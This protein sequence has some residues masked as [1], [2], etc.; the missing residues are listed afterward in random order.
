MTSYILFQQ[1]TDSDLTEDETRDEGNF[2]F[3][4]FLVNVLKFY[5]CLLETCSVTILGAKHVFGKFF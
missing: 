5:F 4:E 1:T 3:L 2:R